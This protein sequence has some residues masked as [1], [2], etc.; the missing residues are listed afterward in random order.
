[1]V[2]CHKNTEVDLKPNMNVAND[3]VISEC[4]YKYIFNM[5]VKAQINPALKANHVTWIDSAWV[6]YN[7]SESEFVFEFSGKMCQDSVQRSGKFEAE[8][9]SSFL[10]PGSTTMVL[11]DNYYDGTNR[12][13]GTD[14]IVY[15]GIT[16]G[17]RMVF[18]NYI[19]HGTILK[20]SANY[21]T[22]TWSSERQFSTDA[23][24]FAQPGNI[25]FLME[26]TCTGISSKDY[27]FSATLDTLTDNINC[28]WILGGIIHLSIPGSG[29]T[30]GTV[31][32]ITNDGCSNKM[33][34]T[35][36]GN[37]FYLWKNPQY[38]KN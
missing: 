26:G 15:N 20:G 13:D 31:D 38:L 32:F 17:K 22:I 7:T 4:A 14:S 24:S 36:E 8:F 28:P 18:T 37:T 12:I 2:S 11:F 21:T 33:K 29:Y 34:Y 23:N 27:S 1:M 30:T 5:I 35:F 9:D 25:I 10:K 19:E 3:V 6:S 16:T